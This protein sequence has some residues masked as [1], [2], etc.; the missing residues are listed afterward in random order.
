MAT[1][2]MTSQR[3]SFEPPSLVDAV[4]VLTPAADPRA[5]LEQVVREFI[6]RFDLRPSLWQL[7]DDERSRRQG[8]PTLDMIKG[9]AP[10]ELTDSFFADGPECG[11]I[12][13]T[14]FTPKPY[15]FP[16]WETYGLKDCWGVRLTGPD[17]SAGDD[18]ARVGRSL[19]S[20][21]AV[22]NALIK[23]C[24]VVRAHVERNA[25][26]FAPTPPHAM[27]G[28]VLFI[29]DRAEI[30]RDYVDPGAYW[31]AWEQA[32]E[33]G[34]GRV[35]L[36]RALTVLD[37]V[38]YKR[39]T[40][41]AA[42]AMAR[43]ARSGLTHYQ[44]HQADELSEAE[45]ALFE[46]GESTLTQVGYHPDEHWIEFTAMVPDGAHIAPRE[47]F[48]LDELV[49]ARQLPDG[50]PLQT[51]RVTFPNQAMAEQEARPLLDIGVTVQFFSEA[52]TW[53]VLSG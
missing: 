16:Y 5:V 22:V 34:E 52:G 46:S 40:Y 25:R 9:L 20:R 42:W 1:L 48:Q 37:E 6:E 26:V 44:H 23:T 10:T 14:R 18:P 15:D 47:I 13:L 53:E 31:R 4:I 8:P 24:P 3:V 36:T 50:R 35:L 2:M 27:P 38:E 45:R 43:A 33:L 17:L 29:A 30:E 39:R 12:H 7:N 19:A 32:T 28:H 49:A 41:P 11:G 21:V 51:V